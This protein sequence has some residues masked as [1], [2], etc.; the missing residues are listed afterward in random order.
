[1]INNDR[2]HGYLLRVTISAKD[3]IRFATIID[4]TS[5]NH[6]RAFMQVTDSYVMYQKSREAK[7]LSRL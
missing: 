4:G 2:M 7:N 5:P 1:M 6:S 3:L